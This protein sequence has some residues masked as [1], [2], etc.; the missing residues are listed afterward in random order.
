M[1]FYVYEKLTDGSNKFRI[2][3]GEKFRKVKYTT[4]K[5]LK[6]MFRPFGL[7]KESKKWSSQKTLKW[8]HQQFLNWSR[9]LNMELHRFTCHQ[10]YRLPNAALFLFQKWGKMPK[11]VQEPDAV[12]N[13]WSEEC[14]NTS[15]I[16][17]ESEEEGEFFSYD[18]KNFFGNMLG[19]R[20]NQ[21]MY[22]PISRGQEYTLEDPN[23]FTQPGIY[24]VKITCPNPEFRKLFSFSKNDTYTHV[25]IEHATQMKKKFPECTIELIRDGEPNA[26]LYKKEDMVCT[27]EI[28][29]GWNMKMV[30]L[31][32]KLPGN[33]LV[34]QLHSSLYSCMGKRYLRTVEPTDQ[35]QIKALEE[36]GYEYSKRNDDGTVSMTNFKR[37]HP[38]GGRIITWLTAK[39]RFRMWQAFK[40]RISDI[41]RVYIDSVLL[42]EPIPVKRLRKICRL[43]Y[44]PEKS[45]F[46]K[47]N[48]K[49]QPIPLE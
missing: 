16:Y 39:A 24:R 46:L 3:D 13:L 22:M 34:K 2:Y 10:F 41:R 21:R 25:S 26:Y 35:D 42:T 8:F 47:L 38:L 45:G 30:E 48:K 37:I 43:K 14:F 1:T 18:F 15:T 49:K 17:G 28:F 40:D 5:D 29:E 20:W 11:N 31:R 12:E 27:K 7:P 44:E 23:Y 4:W 9:E 19:G 36:D 32:E 33:R 6:C